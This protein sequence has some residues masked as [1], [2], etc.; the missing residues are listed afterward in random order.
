LIPALLLPGQKTLNE[1]RQIGCG[2]LGIIP[3]LDVQKTTAAGI[4][5]SQEWAFQT[6]IKQKNEHSRC[7]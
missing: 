4:S 6:R 3:D 2:F 5:K 1:A 7:P